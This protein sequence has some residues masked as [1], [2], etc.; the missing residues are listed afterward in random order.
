MAKERSWDYNAEESEDFVSSTD[1]KQVSAKDFSW[2]ASEYIDHQQTSGWYAGLG[3]ATVVVTAAVFLLTHDIV[4]AVLIPLMG[5]AVGIFSRRKP[6]QLTYILSSDGLQI[7][8]KAYSYG[9][10]KSFAIMSDGGMLSIYLP[11]VKRFMAP[12][13][14][15][16]APADHE[17]IFDILQ[18][19]LPYEERQL[20][21]TER[22]TRRLRF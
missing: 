22:L 19:H 15:Y 11:P 1:K 5:V 12:V 4:A 2:T 3:L 8:G 16:F 21:L 20:E 7:G 6:R 14:A 18:E 13:S 9:L 17:K 10:F